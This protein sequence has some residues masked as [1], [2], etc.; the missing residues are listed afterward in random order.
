MLQLPVRPT[1][2]G[3][4]YDPAALWKPSV[5]LLHVY[6]LPIGSIL[7]V[8][9]VQTELAGM[10]WESHGPNSAELARRTKL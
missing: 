6:R 4:L 7:T 8:K 3:V 5:V 2:E 1:C 9:P 10:Q